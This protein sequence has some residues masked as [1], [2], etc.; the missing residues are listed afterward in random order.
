MAEFS[1][2]AHAFPTSHMLCTPYHLSSYFGPVDTRVDLFIHQS[3][4]HHV[5]A[6]DHI[7]S[8]RLLRRGLIVVLRPDNA[9]DGVFEHEVRDLIAAE[10]CAGESATVDCNDEDLFC[11]KAGCS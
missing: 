4:N 11:V 7:E 2:F 5:I 3:T 8:M 6:S 1:S 9:L 10:E